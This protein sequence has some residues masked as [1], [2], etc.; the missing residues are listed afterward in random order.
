MRAT[1][2]TAV[3]LLNLGAAGEPTASTRFTTIDVVIDTEKQPLAAYQVDI[4]DTRGVARIVGIEGGEHP[5][6]AEP[7]YYD[8][9][10]IQNDR[11]ILAAYSLAGT[12]DLPRG[13]TR[14]ATI[15][16][17]IT[18]GT[19]PDYA[20]R[21]IVAADTAGENI[22]AQLSLRKDPEE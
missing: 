9:A 4:R 12:E 11:V 22:E 21:L 7:P 8:P 14:V 3:L 1:L 10:A 16:V 6:F 13:R 2:L 15:H 5:A 19:E 20:S 17:Q 18:G